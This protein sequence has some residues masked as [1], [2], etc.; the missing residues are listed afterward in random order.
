MKPSLQF[1]A[2][3]MIAAAAAAGCAGKP[4]STSARPQ[5]KHIFLP[6]ETGSRIPRRVVVSADGVTNIIP[7]NVQT[8]NPEAIGEIQRRGSVKSGTGN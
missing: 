3:V 2:G 4:S 8:A 1:W 7:S 5:Q 6:P